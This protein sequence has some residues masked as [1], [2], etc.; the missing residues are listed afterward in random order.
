MKKII[1]LAVMM[2]LASCAL[3]SP[4]PNRKA[5]LAKDGLF[6]KPFTTDYCSEWPDGKLT[7][8]KQ[9]ADCC[10]THDMHYWIGGTKDE[11]IA[12]DKELKRC[13]KNAS[14]SFNGFLMYLGVRMGGKPGNAAYAW[15]YGWT[16]DRDYFELDSDEAKKA[17]QLLEQSD[18]N[19]NEKEKELINI[20]IEQVLIKKIN[21]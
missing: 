8:P 12:S 6:L 11:R 9:W 4:N 20:F 7:D 14:D 18:L 17:Y 2:T 16:K 13:V 10:F 19:K 15:G 3:L 5:D 21:D 1:L